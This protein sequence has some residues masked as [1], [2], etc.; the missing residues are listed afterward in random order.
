[1]VTFS[2]SLFASDTIEYITGTVSKEKAGW[3]SGNEIINYKLFNDT[4]FISGLINA[5]SCGQHYLIVDKGTS[6]IYMQQSDAGFLCDTKCLYSFYVSIAAC[7]KSRYKVRFC[8]RDTIIKQQY[9]FISVIAKNKVVIPEIEILKNGYSG[10]NIHF[11]ENYAKGKISI[12]D[13][14]GKEIATKTIYNDADVEMEVGHRIVGVFLIN[15]QVGDKH[16]TSKMLFQ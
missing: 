10:L 16:Y 14:L 12:Y 11:S 9:D 5:N 8:G 2:R 13:M 4:L 7:N 15:I 6:D 1:M 3:I